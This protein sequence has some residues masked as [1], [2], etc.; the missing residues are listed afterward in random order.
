MLAERIENQKSWMA[1]L[2]T[3]EYF[4]AWELVTGNV[5]IYAS[6][7]I[8][9]QYHGAFFEEEAPEAQKVRYTSWKELRPHFLALIRG[10]RL[11]LSFKFIFRLP[12]KETADLIRESGSG[13]PPED[14]YGLYLNLGYENGEMTLTT[15]SSYRSFLPERTL[16]RAFDEYIEK[17]FV[18][19]L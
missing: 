5:V 9:G 6:F 10:K 17:Y 15:G 1:A 4:D 11:P 8:D 13:I 3:S 18:S 16:D 19:T 7:T 12:D 14:V 2:L